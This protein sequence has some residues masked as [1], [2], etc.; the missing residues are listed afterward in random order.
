M[1]L[2]GNWGEIC[3]I[4]FM[5]LT[6]M[7]FYY[8]GSSYTA[9]L[10]NARKAENLVSKGHNGWGVENRRDTCTWYVYVSFYVTRHGTSGLDGW[11]AII[12][13]WEY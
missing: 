1:K 10:G 3:S 13:F 2:V 7:L 4:P 12:S 11:M 9:I 5:C 8:F 6:A